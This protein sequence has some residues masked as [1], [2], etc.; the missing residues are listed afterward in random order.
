MFPAPACGSHAT[1]GRD[2]PRGPLSRS[3]RGGTVPATRRPAELVGGL[4]RP[5]GV[6][7]QL[8]AER[9]EVGPPVPHERVGVGRLRDPAD[10]GDGHVGPIPDRLGVRHLVP[11]TRARELLVRVDTAAGDVDQVRPGVGEERGQPHR[12][13]HVPRVAVREPVGRRDAD[14]HG[15]PVGPDVADGGDDLAQEPRAVLEAPAVLVVAVVGDGRAELVE[16][17]AVGR[18]DLRDLETDV[19]RAL[20]GGR[21]RVDHLRDPVGV[22]PSSG[23]RLAALAVAPVAARIRLVGRGDGLP[24]VRLVR[25]DGSAP[26]GGRSVGR[27][28]PGVGQLDP[29]RRALRPDELDDRFDRL[30]VLVGPDPEAVRRDPPA[31]LDRGRLRHHDPGSPGGARAEVD[32]VPVGRQPALGGVLAHRRQHHPVSDLGVAERERCEQRVGHGSANDR[33]HVRPSD[34][35][36]GSPPM[37]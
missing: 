18:V 3:G 30:G 24:P 25:G 23:R 7:E 16:E 37:V 6:P 11:G 32:S 1:A 31:G 4:Q 12:V 20:R 36:R 34:P 17:V 2:G 35:P 9:H 33:R 13:V 8:A 29:R 22:E 5:V 21:E 27:L 19:A 28:P 10:R 14:E 26:L 15:L